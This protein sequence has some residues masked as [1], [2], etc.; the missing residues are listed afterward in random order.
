[1]LDVDDFLAEQEISEEAKEI[2]IGTLAAHFLAGSINFAGFSIMHAH[3][4]LPEPTAHQQEY[5][6]PNFHWAMLQ[7]LVKA[8][9]N[10]W[11][12]S[13]ALLTL[14]PYMLGP[15]HWKHAVKVLR[16]LKKI[17]QFVD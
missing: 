14:Q 1:M 16:I 17:P 4:K 5:P 12:V 6:G 8:G 2:L 9:A 13:Q 10:F 15:G 3:F 7:V 11:R